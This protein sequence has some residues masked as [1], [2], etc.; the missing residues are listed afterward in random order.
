MFE[1]QLLIG[2]SGDGT[3]V[4]SPWFPRQGDNA[5]FT[6][7]VVAISGVTLSVE[8]FTKNTEDAGNGSPVSPA[9]GSLSG[10]VDPGAVA[11]TWGPDTLLELVR[12]RYTVESAGDWVLFRMLTPVWSDS[13]AE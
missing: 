3:R 11:A 7:D 6:V 12:Y 10:I 9:S 5:I 2:S 1:A 13:V 8:V 4:F